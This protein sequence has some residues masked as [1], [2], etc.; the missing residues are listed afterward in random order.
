MHT[1]TRTYPD[2]TRASYT[3]RPGSEAA[4]ALTRPVK[5]HKQPRKGE[6]RSYPKF[7]HFMSTAEYVRAYYRANSIGRPDHFAPLNT[8]PATPYLGLDTVETVEE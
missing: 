3:L 2:G 7:T 8:A 4:D 5:P 6:K 1:L